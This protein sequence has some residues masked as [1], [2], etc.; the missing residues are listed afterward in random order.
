[1]RALIIA[2]GPAVR[3]RP[4]TNATPKCLIKVY[5]KSLLERMIDPLLE[6]GVDDFVIITGHLESQVKKLVKQKY[7]KLK[8]KLFRTPSIKMNYLYPMWS[9]RKLLEGEDILY[10]HG[11]VIFDPA[12]AK[13][14]I[15]F[16]HSGALVRK[17]FVSQ[18]DFNALVKNGL[19]KKIG[20]KIFDKGAGFCLPFYKLQADDFR[21]WIKQM[22][23]YVKAKKFKNYAEDALNEILEEVKLYPVYYDRQLGMEIDDLEDLNLAKSFL[24]K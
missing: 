11:D 3:L 12:L 7:P 23:A 18:K 13:K 4:L 22:E 15:E 19:I 9:A 5:Q 20:V 16:P 21:A 24:S 1:M 10:L 17:D 8:I 2:G 14:L 6:N